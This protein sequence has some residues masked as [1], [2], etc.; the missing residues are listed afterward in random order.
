MHQDCG[1]HLAKS[2]K[3][4]TKTTFGKKMLQSTPQMLKDLQLDLCRYNALIIDEC[5]KIPVTSLI[6]DVV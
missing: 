3:I 2:S 4:D 6:G 5:P 1:L